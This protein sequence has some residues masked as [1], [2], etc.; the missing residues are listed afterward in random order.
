MQKPFQSPQNHLLSHTIRFLHGEEKDFE[1]IKS[2]ADHSSIPHL[3]FTFSFLINWL[4]YQLYE[5]YGHE[6][7]SNTIFR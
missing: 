3:T 4:L 7:C 1:M 5:K 2:L 6:S